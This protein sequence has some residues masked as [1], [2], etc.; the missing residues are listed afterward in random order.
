MTNSIKALVCSAA[1][2]AAV[3]SLPAQSKSGILQPQMTVGADG[4]TYAKPMGT[5]G[6]KPAQPW[7]ATT[8]GASV[9]GKPNPGG[10]VKTV[11]GEVVDFSCYLEVGKHGE[12][13]RDCAQKCM[14]NGEPIGLLTQDGTL[15]MLMAEEHDP[16][17]DGQTTFRQ[18][19]ID[20]AGHI[21]QVSGTE[22]SLNGYH[23]LYV[24]GTAKK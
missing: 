3:V 23:A 13:H 24:Q 6:E 9:N 17:R 14:R 16:R 1:V 19:A 12:K 10:A 5:L 22:W 7:S 20:H 8:I 21:M 18:M 15:Y 2:F 4:G 11:T